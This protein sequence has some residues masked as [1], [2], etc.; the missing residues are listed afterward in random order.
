MLHARTDILHATCHGARFLYTPPDVA[1]NRTAADLPLPTS[2]YTVIAGRLATYL[3]YSGLLLSSVRH[4]YHRSSSSWHFAM[5]RHTLFASRTF[6]RNLSPA[7]CSAVPAAE[8]GG[9]PYHLQLPF[10]PCI[11]AVL[12]HFAVR[13]GVV[14][15]RA[16]P[17]TPTMTPPSDLLPV[18][19]SPLHLKQGAYSRGS[20]CSEQWFRLVRW[21]SRFGARHAC[22]WRGVLGSFCD[23]SVCAA[24]L[25]RYM[26]W[27]PCG[28]CWRCCG[29]PT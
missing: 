1:R 7:A 9:R 18:M 4:Y 24:F 19:P 25:G 11:P 2:H 8:E 27:M 29:E 13:C 15:G 28:S 23:C 5:A 16:Q 6:Y 14:G 26:A 3:L 10:L 17:Q 21:R 12:R 22:T 20:L